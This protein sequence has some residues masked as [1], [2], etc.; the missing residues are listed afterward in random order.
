MRTHMRHTP[1]MEGGEVSSSGAAVDA[2]TRS[3]A[4]R[5]GDIFARTAT[6]DEAVVGQQAQRNLMA[7]GSELRVVQRR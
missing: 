5:V 7:G 3:S 4:N 6:P 1:A 2:R